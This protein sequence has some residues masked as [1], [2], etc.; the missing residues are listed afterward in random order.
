MTVYLVFDC[1]G[2]EGDV[3]LAAFSSSDKAVDYVRRAHGQDDGSI[4]IGNGIQETFI[5]KQTVDSDEGG[6]RVFRK[7]TME[8]N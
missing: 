6:E 1:Y 2:Y 7:L 5:I 4:I 3:F 8:V